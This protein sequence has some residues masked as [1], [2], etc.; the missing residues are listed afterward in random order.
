MTVTAGQGARPEHVDLVRNRFQMVWIGTVR[1]T[2]EMVKFQV[3]RYL[4]DEHLVGPPMHFLHRL[5]RNWTK[6]GIAIR[7]ERSLPEPTTILCHEDF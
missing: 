2:A 7:R 1:V 5:S 4:S 3:F 6:L